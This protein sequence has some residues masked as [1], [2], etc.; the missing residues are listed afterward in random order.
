M[1]LHIE[2]RKEKVGKV[3]KTLWVDTCGAFC[4]NVIIKSRG[5]M[6]NPKEFPESLHNQN[7]QKISKNPE[8]D[9]AWTQTANH[10][11]NVTFIFWSKQHHKVQ[12]LTIFSSLPF[13]S[14]TTAR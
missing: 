6:V 8:L 10:N 14:A 2:I 1:G 12:V 11:V 5:L 4:V 3:G 13:Q 7:I 9:T